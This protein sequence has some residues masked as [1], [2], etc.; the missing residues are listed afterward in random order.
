MIIV[1]DITDRKSYNHVTKWL[2]DVRKSC[3]NSD[4]IIMLVG[5]KHDMRHIRCV[6]TEEAK[7]FANA[8]HVLFVETSARDCT[9]VKLAFNTVIENTI[10][11]RTMQEM[12]EKLP[13]SAGNVRL[14]QSTNKKK[15]GCCKT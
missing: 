5:N 1:Y 4:V 3:D 11:A 8:N 13:R 7:A 2:D 14:K 6:E 12:N 9:N 10:Q 15:M